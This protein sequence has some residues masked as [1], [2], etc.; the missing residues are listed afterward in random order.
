MIRVNPEPHA[1]LV[2]RVF[3]RE[4]FV[5]VTSPDFHRPDAAPV[6]AVVRG[7]IR[8]RTTWEVL[9]SSG[10][11]SIAVDPIFGRSSRMMVRTR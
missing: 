4:R 3:L 8:Q 6:P 2:V 5:G 1:A 11:M 10:K 9:H 7:T